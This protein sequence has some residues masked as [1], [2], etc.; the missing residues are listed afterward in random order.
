LIKYLYH[1]NIYFIFLHAIVCGWIDDARLKEAQ[2]YNY[3][4]TSTI[5]NFFSA[6]SFFYI[7]KGLAFRLEACSIV[8]SDECVVDSLESLRRIRLDATRWLELISDIQRM[9]IAMFYKASWRL[10]RRPSV[11]QGL[12]AGSAGVRDSSVRSGIHDCTYPPHRSTC[13]QCRYLPSCTFHPL[14]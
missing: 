4:D 3:S 1:R 12:S 13:D 2:N 14:P 11:E 6:I 5:F 7:S 10:L 8:R 9:M